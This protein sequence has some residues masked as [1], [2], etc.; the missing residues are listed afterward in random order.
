MT[1]MRLLQ[2]VYMRIQAVLWQ[3]YKNIVAF[4]SIV[5][6]TLHNAGLVHR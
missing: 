3:V 5:T 2:A 6:S 1:V 4:C